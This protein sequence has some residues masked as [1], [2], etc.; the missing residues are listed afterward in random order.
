MKVSFPH[1]GYLSIPV[2]NMLT[3]LGVE[4]VE[5]PPITKTTV[6]LGSAYSPEGACLPYKIIMGNFLECMDRGADTFV[7][8]CGAGKCR[9]GF[10]NAI[11]KIQL[12][13]RKN[14]QFYA[15]D[16][17]NLFRSIYHFLRKT[18]PD[19]G[20]M[21]IL[22]QLA[23]AVKSLQALDAINEA[24]SRFGSRS[25]APDSIIDIANNSFKEF[26]NC[27]TFA[28]IHYKKD[29]ILDLLQP[30]GVDTGLE[31][32]KVAL[33][34][35]LYLL[36][37][38]YVNHYI[39]DVLVRQG[40]EV[41]KFIYTGDW[42]YTNTLLSGLG[43]Y[44]EEKAYQKQAKPYLNHHVGGDGLKSVGTA[45]GCA[46]KGYAGVIHIY[47]FGCMPEV[48]AQ[49]ALKNIASDFNL[50]MLSLSI[51]EHAS[52]VGILTRIEAFVDCIKRRQQGEKKKH[53]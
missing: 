2:T 42:V 37:E 4:V 6:D 18:V 11:Q 33:V 24:K 8:V 23:V 38:P 44:N 53:S 49:Y 7:S 19:A 20:H 35:E 3:S 51:D 31:P 26:G 40:V 13:K 10:Y 29:K 21:T 48:V 1:M 22:K 25:H 14:I 16:T 45:L 36:L 27:Q 43:L 28:D 15:I 34:G 30:F 9:L 5:T 50:P 39:E 32:P 47:P 46:Q 17:N 12:S 52:D 41:K